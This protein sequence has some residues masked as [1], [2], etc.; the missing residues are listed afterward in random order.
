M[1]KKQAESK[2]LKTSILRI[3]KLGF[4]FVFIYAISTLVY[5]LWGLLTPEILMQRWIV[6]LLVLSVVSV[7]WW[8]SKG[9]MLTATYYK[10]LIMLQILMYLAVAAYSI[11]SERG[12]ASNS[13]VLF[14]IPI[15]IV[16]LEYNGKAL[17]ST[18]ALS[19]LVYSSA[20]IKYF[21]DYPSEGYKVELYGGL[22]FYASILLLVAGLL[23]VLMRSKKVAR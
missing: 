3:T 10:G 8:H 4:A 20:S 16:A 19:I 12:M 23:W 11:Y 7:L 2:R 22:F 21:K 17:L 13:V 14:T 15:V 5:K 1:T 9:K 18:T 6:T